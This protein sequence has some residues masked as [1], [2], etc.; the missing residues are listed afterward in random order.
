MKLLF[1]HP[2][3]AG[4]GAG[5]GERDTEREEVL[6][7]FCAHRP[8]EASLSQRSRPSLSSVCR[9]KSKPS[10]NFHSLKLETF[11]LNSHMNVW[12]PTAEMLKFSTHI[13]NI[14]TRV[15]AVFYYSSHRGV[16]ERE[17]ER[18]MMTICHFIS[19]HLFR[20]T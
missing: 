18:I 19:N 5:A 1:S 12:R 3:L 7:V 8:V 13:N 15:P 2:A 4:A 14:E 6:L 11:S 17:R 10:T 9:K 16:S 20:M